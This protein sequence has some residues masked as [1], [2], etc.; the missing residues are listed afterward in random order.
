VGDAV[1][2]LL[3]GFCFLIEV[4]RI[5]GNSAGAGADDGPDGGDIFVGLGTVKSGNA[6][7]KRKRL[8]GPVLAMLV[9]GEVAGDR[10]EP[11]IEVEGPRPDGMQATECPDEGLLDQGLGQVPVTDKTEH[12]SLE[13]RL[14]IGTEGAK[15]FTVPITYTLQKWNHANE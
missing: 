15:R 3:P 6:L 8:V 14:D 1:L 7:V 9:A 10:I 13:G 11:G 12:M 4:G 5:L 2:M